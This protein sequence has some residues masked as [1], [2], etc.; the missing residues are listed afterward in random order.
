MSRTAP[1]TFTIHD[2]NSAQARR[3]M[4]IER[5]KFVPAALPPRFLGRNPSKGGAM[6]KL[7][8]DLAIYGCNVNPRRAGTTGGQ[9]VVISRRPKLA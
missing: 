4:P 8:D 9:G 5:P 1:R 3:L 6:G 7:C 2:V